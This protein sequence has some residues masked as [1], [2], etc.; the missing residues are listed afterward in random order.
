MIVANDYH[1]LKWIA[2]ICYKDL[3]CAQGEHGQIGTSWL[4][5]KGGAQS[6]ISVG[7]Q[8]EYGQQRE[9]TSWSALCP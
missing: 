3:A 6:E 1:G 5:Y 4:I 2:S 9:R 8:G 7:T